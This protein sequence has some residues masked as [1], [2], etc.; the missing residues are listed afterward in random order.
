MNPVEVVKQRMQMMYSP[1]GGS[2]EC[3]KCI[4]R[5]EGM[6]AFYRSYATQ[7]AMNIPFQ[8]IHFMTY[9]FCQQVSFLSVTEKF[10]KLN[11]FIFK[12]TFIFDLF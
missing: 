12:V 2:L 10:R 11:V 6:P 8:S 3:V 5:N 9:E 1:Y 7:L 4:Y